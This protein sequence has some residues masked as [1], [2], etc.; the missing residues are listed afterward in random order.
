VKTATIYRFESISLQRGVR[1]ELDPAASATGGL[2]IDRFAP[3]LPFAIPV[4]IASVG[5]K[6][7]FHPLR[8]IVSRSPKSSVRCA[9]EPPIL[10]MHAI[11]PAPRSLVQKYLSCPKSRARTGGRSPAGRRAVCEVEPRCKFTGGNDWLR[12]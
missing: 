2:E 7:P 11:T 10:E 12:L 4:G 9:S 5:G 8:V 6:P 1:R 3:H